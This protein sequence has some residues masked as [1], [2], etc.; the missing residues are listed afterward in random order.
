MVHA[1]IPVY[2]AQPYSMVLNKAD[3]EKYK[4]PFERE[5]QVQ[6]SRAPPAFAVKTW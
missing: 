3:K 5:M 2:T 4:A 1:S 6:Q